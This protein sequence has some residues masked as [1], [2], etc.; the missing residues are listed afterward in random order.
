MELEHNHKI[1]IKIM[2]M[3]MAKNIYSQKDSFAI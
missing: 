3:M 2:M 1:V